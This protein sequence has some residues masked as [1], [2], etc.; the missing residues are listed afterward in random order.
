MPLPAFFA[1]PLAGALAGGALSFLGGSKRNEAQIASAREQMA[2]QE[3]MS[4][5]A[6]QRQVAD[7]RAAG[8]NP[9]LSAKYGGASSPGGAMPQIQDVL[10]PAVNTGLS[11]MKTRAD[12][13]VAEKTANK[14]IQDTKTS[15]AQEW[16]ND[17]AR[18]LKSLEYNQ[19]LEVIQILKQELIK[20][21]REGAVTGSKFGYAMR[22][23]KEFIDTF[24][25]LSGA[26]RDVQSGRR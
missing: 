12:V 5:T 20:M 22:Y 10:T 24:N 3:R 9:I 14:I 16:L 25:P 2:F 7:L 1:T 18:A 15:N 19:R 4:N 17:S 13:N 26:F 8:L 21:E 11:V 6:H 23:I